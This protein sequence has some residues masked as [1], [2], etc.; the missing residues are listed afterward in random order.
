MQRSE[1][2]KRR[3]RSGRS[4]FAR[5]GAARLRAGES[6]P[7]REEENSAEGDAKR[8]AHVEQLGLRRVAEHRVLGRA[9]DGELLADDLDASGPST[10][11][12][13]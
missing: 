2:E 10:S 8:R 3:P 12:S 11:P 5:A 6:A 9:G 13:A 1:E 7:V 4:R